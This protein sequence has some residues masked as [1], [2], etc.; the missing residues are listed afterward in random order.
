MEMGVGSEGHAVRMEKE[1]NSPR[2]NSNLAPNWP[3]DKNPFIL[4]SSV[5]FHADEL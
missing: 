3:T 2:A 5:W 4:H 1:P